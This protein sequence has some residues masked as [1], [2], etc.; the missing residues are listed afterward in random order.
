MSGQHLPGA[1]GYMLDRT[2]VYAARLPGGAIRSRDGRDEASDVPRN[3][4]NAAP[5]AAMARRT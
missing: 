4:C 3:G 1:A 2:D 5:T